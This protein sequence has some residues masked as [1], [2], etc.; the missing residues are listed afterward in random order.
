VAH[1]VVEPARSRP[2]TPGGLATTPR[3]V[4]DTNVWLDLLVFDDPRVAPV[5]AALASGELVVVSNDDCRAEWCR[6]LAYPQLRLDPLRQAEL[7]AAYDG[8]TVPVEAPATNAVP[9]CAD[10]DDQKFVELA[11]ASGASWLLSRDAALLALA[12][13]TE[14]AGLFRIAT[15]DAWSLQ[16]AATG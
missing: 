8:L 4:L 13:R 9:R 2:L 6:V 15:P 12:R 7:R 16:R 3:I 14:R 11:S 5:R 10:P 1:R